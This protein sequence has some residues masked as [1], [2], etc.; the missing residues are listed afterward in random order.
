MV[1]QATETIVVLAIIDQLL[2]TSA[3][4]EFAGLHPPHPALRQGEL[5]TVRLPLSGRAQSLVRAHREVH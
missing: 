3:V 5:V 1:T 4:L 2:R